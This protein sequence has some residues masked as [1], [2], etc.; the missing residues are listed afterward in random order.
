MELVKRHAGEH[1]SQRRFVGCAACL[2]S[3]GRTEDRPAGTVTTSRSISPALPLKALQCAGGL[4]TR[5]DIGAP[6]FG[7]SITGPL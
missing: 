4:K 3:I 6:I 2:P 7:V 5:T 1:I